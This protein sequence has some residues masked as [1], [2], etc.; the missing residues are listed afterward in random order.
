MF[1][2]A[3]SAAAA[4]AVTPFSAAPLTANPT[5]LFAQVASVANAGGTA[6]GSQLLTTVPQALQLLATP[7]ASAAS[8]ASS[9]PSSL[10]SF[11]GLGTPPTALMGPGS[12]FATG[13]MLNNLGISSPVNALTTLS[14]L[15]ANSMNGTQLASWVNMA[16]KP[17]AA[18]A[19]GAANAAQAATGA[20]LAGPGGLGGGPSVAASLGNAT[21]L[22]RL[23]VP[24]AWT[25]AAPTVTAP[26]ATPLPAVGAAESGGPGSML[27]GVPLAGGAGGRASN[28]GIG[29]PRYGFRL[30]VMSRPPA[31]G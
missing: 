14:S 1:G 9:S 31:A 23:S 16:P 25:G 10:L 30:S 17:A 20:G 24:P 6:A 3:G 28:S 4:S 27:G 5:G 8:K 2:Y 18:A 21:S 22:G 19:A 15:G 29:D 12:V 26:A 13:G 11:L 7:L